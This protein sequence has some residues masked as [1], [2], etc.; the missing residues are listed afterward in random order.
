MI[1][2]KK[3]C[4]PAVCTLQIIF[5]FQFVFFQIQKSIRMAAEKLD[6]Q[7]GE[8]CDCSGYKAYN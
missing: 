2:Q 4:I 5:R 6:E 8:A 3:G 7:E 1:H